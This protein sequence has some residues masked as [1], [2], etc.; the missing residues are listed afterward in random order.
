VIDAGSGVTITCVQ[1]FP[2]LDK[3]GVFEIPVSPAV[4]RANDT[5]QP[6]VL[7]QPHAPESQ[8]RTHLSGRRDRHHHPYTSTGSSSSP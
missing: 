5:G 6:V 8:V 2:G 1:A 4:S 3:T 7:A